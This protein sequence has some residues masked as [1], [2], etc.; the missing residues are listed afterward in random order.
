MKNLRIIREQKG[1][2]QSE[3]AKALNI[4]RQSYN[5]YEND[6]RDPDTAMVKKIA[7][8]FS[9]TTD[10]ILGNSPDQPETPSTPHPALT[11]KDEAEIA[12]DLEAMLASL[13]ADNGMAAYNEPEDEEDR[14]L[15]KA[16]LLTSMRLAKQMAKKKF[17]PKKYRKE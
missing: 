14:E 9:V 4:S 6:K 3:V 11:P 1:L 10:Y 8:Y 7:E 12:R 15:L 5:F 13:D 16:S 17:T 2:S